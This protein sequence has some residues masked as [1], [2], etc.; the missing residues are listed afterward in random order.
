MDREECTFFV[1][2]IW[3]ALAAARL[4]YEAA[5]QI[6]CRLGT[7]V[8]SRVRVSVFFMSLA[9]IL[10]ASVGSLLWS[11]IHPEGFKDLSSALLTISI[12]LG[13]VFGAIVGEDPM[14]KFVSDS[15]L[16]S[17]TLRRAA[18]GGG[19]SALI[20]VAI[21][22]ILIALFFSMPF[23]GA[24]PLSSL[25]AFLA[26]GLWTLGFV[27]TIFGLP[28]VLLGSLCGILIQITWSKYGRQA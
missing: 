3:S 28:A 14:S 7:T 23:F 8:K 25:T 18:L 26:V 17:K 16:H 11:V 4:S 24:E 20:A 22:S 6:Y 19:I 2:T 27:L 5:D 21:P 15:P 9:G 13:A 1:H 12:I 10:A